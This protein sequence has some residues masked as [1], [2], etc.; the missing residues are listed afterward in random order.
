MALKRCTSTEMRWYKKLPSPVLTEILKP[1]S[2]DRAL[3]EEL[4]T[5]RVSTAIVLLIRQKSSTIEAN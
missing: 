5:P 4:K 1:I 3:A 2:F